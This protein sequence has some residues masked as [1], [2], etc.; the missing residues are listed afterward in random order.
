MTNS[1]ETWF[2]PTY[3]AN[4]KTNI[5]KIF[6]K[7]VDKNFPHQHKYYKIFDRNNIKLS[8][9]CMRN[10]NN[11]IQK[12]NSKIMKSPAPFT[13]KTCNLLRKTNCS[14]DGKCL[15]ECLIYKASVRRTTDK[16]CYGTCENTFKVHYNNRKCSF[17]HKSLEKKTEFSKYINYFIN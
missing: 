9:S 3:S 10:M 14:M 5:G 12:H 7:F 8:Y 6:M 16:N 13:T 15:F 1:K 4:V 17:R 11:I 2:N